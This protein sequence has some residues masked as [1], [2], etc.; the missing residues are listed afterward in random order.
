MLVFF[1][2]SSLLFFSYFGYYLI[3]SQQQTA[4]SHSGWEVFTR[5]FSETGVQQ[6]SILCTTLFL[7]YINDFL[8]DVICNIVIYAD[9]T[10]L[11]TN[12]DQVLIYGNNQICLLNLPLS[13][14]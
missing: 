6:D 5:T 1:L 4:L 12:C 11:Y 2:T 7:L 13:F 14:D 10:N 8:L 3:F 9:D